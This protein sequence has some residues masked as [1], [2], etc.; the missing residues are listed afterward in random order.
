MWRSVI[1]GYVL[2]DAKIIRPLRERM[3]FFASLINRNR[4]AVDSGMES[5]PTR[6]RRG[7]KRGRSTP[8]AHV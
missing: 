3:L 5:H 8:F 1:A 7:F 4:Q 6:L 2:A